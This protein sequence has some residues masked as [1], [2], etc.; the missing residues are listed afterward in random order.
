M[1]LKEYIEVKPIWSK[2]PATNREILTEVIEISLQSILPFVCGFYFLKTRNVLFLLV[3][4]FI[5]FF[6]FEVKK[7]GL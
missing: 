3:F 5:I 7:D 6:H 1:R 4:V 2:K